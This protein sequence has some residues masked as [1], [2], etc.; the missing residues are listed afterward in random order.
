MDSRSGTDTISHPVPSGAI[1]G[2]SFPAIALTIL[3]LIVYLPIFL[4]FPGRDSGVFLY[5]GQRIL[6]GKVPYVDFWD[7][8]PP[9]VYLINAT[10]LY[11]GTGSVYGV[12]TIELLCLFLAAAFSF[13]AL[14][15]AFGTLPA[16]CAS[17]IWILNLPNV[18]ENGNFT[19][20]YGLV[21]Q[22]GAVLLFTLALEKEKHIFYG[23]GI[24]I[25]L[26]IAFF[27][28]QNLVGV[29][30][31]IAIYCLYE[32]FVKKNVGIIKNIFF[33]MVAGFLLLGFI[34]VGFFVVK[35][36]MAQFWD[37]VF[38]YN[39]CYTA[40]KSAR[41]RFHSICSGM[42]SFPAWVSVVVV[43]GWFLAFLYV[44]NPSPENNSALFLTVLSILLFPVELLLSSLSGRSYDHYF[45][46]YLP[47]ISLLSGFFIYFIVEQAQSLT[48]AIKY[49]KVNPGY[50][51]V[52]FLMLTAVFTQGKIVHEK[53]L[54]NVLN[55]RPDKKEQ[56]IKNI[57]SY[58]AA[59]TNQ[60]DYVL[61]W[62]DEPII[63]FLSGRTSPSR[64]FYQYPL[65]TRG[66]SSRS[67]IKE[68]INDV[69]NHHT[70]IIIDT[71]GNILPPLDEKERSTWHLS[72]RARAYGYSK[73]PDL[74]GKFYDYVGKNYELAKRI[75]HWDIYIIRKKR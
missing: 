15:K 25:L 32:F 65:V 20:E 58:V 22:F 51:V 43:S 50:F 67:L 18:I 59:V 44:K 60:G 17:A 27:L 41:L 48:F 71:P 4:S 54:V 70:P 12:R 55:T 35:H 6:E 7:H 42:G 61:V 37:C 66:Y 2:L 45:L 74:I 49:L 23:L 52:F 8:K 11:L 46:S 63:N 68:F 14:K 53:Y 64:F 21:C 40:G 62:G 13:A 34:T 57:A 29:W 26:G 56:I 30:G 69:Q 38:K 73:P 72:A 9:V 33:P 24:G 36:G 1:K 39:F 5:A 19:E 3:L 10:G 31:A 16:L 47:F 28:K 75:G